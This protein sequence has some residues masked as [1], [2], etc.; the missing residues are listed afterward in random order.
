MPSRPPLPAAVAVSPDRGSRVQRWTSCE[1]TTRPSGATEGARSDAAFRV[2]RIAC[3]PS[4][5]ALQI[6]LVSESRFP[7][8]GSGPLS[9]NRILDPSGDQ[10]GFP[11]SVVSD[12]IR[13]GFVS[14]PLL[15]GASATKISADPLRP[16][17][18]ATREPSGD[19]AGWFTG[20]RALMVRNRECCPSRS[21][22]AILVP[23][24]HP[25]QKPT[26]GSAVTYAIVRPS[27][28]TANP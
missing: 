12:V 4:A 1:K 19:Q 15:P 10:V 3:P 11:S 9:S 16:E 17:T 26:V 5:G 24:P 22:A 28:E 23:G 6:S 25:P 2:R 13:S 20:D 14:G 27:G 18:N 21:I 7:S 8:S